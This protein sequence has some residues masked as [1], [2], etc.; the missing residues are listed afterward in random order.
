MITLL[1]ALQPASGPGSD[2]PWRRGASCAPVWTTA[3]VRITGEDLVV[4]SL[5]GPGRSIEMDDLR[6]GR[7]VMPRSAVDSLLRASRER[8]LALAITTIY[9]LISV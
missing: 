9:W 6:A 7:A 3:E 8:S 5:P 4:L 2:E 1:G